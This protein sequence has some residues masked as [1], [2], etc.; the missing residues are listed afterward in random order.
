MYII[1]IIVFLFFI[2]IIIIIII[3][4]SSSSSIVIIIIS[5]SSSSSIVF[6]YNIIKLCIFKYYGAIVNSRWT[7]YSAH[8]PSL[9]NTDSEFCI[10]TGCTFVLCVLSICLSLL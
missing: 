6:Y 7:N 5:S 1:I 2:I 10:H 9:G 3:I 4:S 8:T